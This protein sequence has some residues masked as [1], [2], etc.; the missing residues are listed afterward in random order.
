MMRGPKITSVT[1]GG[2]TS[3]STAPIVIK[4]KF[5]GN[6]KG[7]VTLEKDGAVKSC[8]VL[9]W[10]MDV[11]PGEDEIQFLVPKKLATATDYVLKVTNKVNSYT[12]TFA[13]T[14]P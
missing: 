7:K 10:T 12:T 3:G 13:V 2:G 8:K 11:T 6:K 5:F 4:G 1:P 14:A 9:S